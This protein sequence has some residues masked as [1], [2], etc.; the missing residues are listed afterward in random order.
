[1]SK[2]LF[3]TWTE[4]TQEFSNWRVISGGLGTEP[5]FKTKTIRKYARWSNDTSEEMRQKA[6]LYIQT[7]MQDRPDAKVVLR[8]N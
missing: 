5:V 4:Q 6:E 7:D 3:I 1:M 2:A 8:E